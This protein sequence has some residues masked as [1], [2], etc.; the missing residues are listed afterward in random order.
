MDQEMTKQQRDDL[1]EKFIRTIDAQA[2]KT[3]KLF[4]L[5]FIGLCGVGK[6]FVAQKISERLGLYVFSSD[7]TRR[8]LND[9][10]IEG[11]NP[12]QEFVEY[13]G[14]VSS[15]YLFEK[16]ISHIIDGDLI[17][18]HPIT[19]KNAEDNGAHFY[20]INF[21]CPEDIILAR[22]DRRC[23]ENDSNNLSRAG[24][25][26]YFKRKA[27]HESLP[28]PEVFF[29]IDTSRDVDAQLDELINRLREEKVI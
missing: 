2:G 4:T 25:E 12:S 18:L 26:V 20:M 28:M 13:I 15:R 22:I 23:R 11:I 24:R 3:K 7:R 14:P 10:G 5:G 29:T 9:Q 16:N 19:R 17:K 1:A 8:F 6:S 21:I 27:M